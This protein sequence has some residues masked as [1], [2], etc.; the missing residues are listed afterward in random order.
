MATLA[1][2]K[3]TTGAIGNREELGDKISRIYASQLPF[4]VSGG[5]GKA[6]T[7]APDWLTEDVRA[8]ALGNAGLEG[9]T[10][11]ITAPSQRVRVGNK[12]QIFREGGSVS[13]TQEVVDKAGVAS[14]F[15]RQKL[16]KGLAVS[17]DKEATYCSAQA[18]GDEVP[19][20]TG[21]LMGG[22]QAWVDNNSDRGAT[23]ADGGYTGGLVTAPTTGTNRVFAESQLKAVLKSMFENGAVG[24]KRA[25][26]AADLKEKFS[27]FTGI[28]SI[29]TEVRGRNKAV[30]HAAADV[31]VSDF[32]DVT[33]MAHQF[34]LAEECLVYMPST[35][36]VLTLRPTKSSGLSKN[37]D[38]QEFQ[39][40]GEE[41]LKIAN[42]K[43]IGIVA[44]I[45]AA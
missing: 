1:N 3:V 4:M 39:I 5:K 11:N 31:Y 41:T 2:T 7:I 33:A 35:V 16:I 25:L 17:L 24:D 13:G 19:A 12:T 8:P 45:T 27:E 21:R 26:M 28:S 34:A 38:S 23:G 37:G 32:G 36:S 20:T 6:K 43:Q 14:E 9:D 30:I 18:S 44:D 40:V 29:R 42:T 15:A 22:V 10:A